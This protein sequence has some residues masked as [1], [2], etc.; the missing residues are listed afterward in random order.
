MRTAKFL[1]LLLLVLSA[2]CTSTVPA[3]VTRGPL[4]PVM[5]NPR[6]F[7][8]AANQSVR[9]V[10]SLR[11][12]GFTVKEGF[13]DVDYTLEVRIG[14]SRASRE[15]GSVNNVIY[16]L[17]QS[18]QQFM[19]IKGRGLTGSCSPNVFDDMSRKLAAYYVDSG[20]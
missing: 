12:A 11:D 2:A 6:I 4:G 14:D 9:I 18:G 17:N 19:I 10:R 5:T 16:I 7:V 15:C 1:V 8:S 3:T 13:R 20:A